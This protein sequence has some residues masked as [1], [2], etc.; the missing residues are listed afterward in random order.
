MASR[1]HLKV[2]KDILED[3]SVNSDYISKLIESKQASRL[4]RLVAEIMPEQLSKVD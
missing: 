4:I 1:Y 2:L 3:K